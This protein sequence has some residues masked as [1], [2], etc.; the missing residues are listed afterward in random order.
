MD[1]MKRLLTELDEKFIPVQ[2]QLKEIH[3]R[4]DRDE[5]IAASND[6]ELLRSALS[7]SLGE[8]KTMT[9]LVTSVTMYVRA[10][11]NATIKAMEDERG[12]NT[13]DKTSNVVRGEGQA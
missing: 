3:A 10:F 6:I 13:G 11:A 12:E 9:E 2:R 4:I 1:E 5:A 8:R 7:Q